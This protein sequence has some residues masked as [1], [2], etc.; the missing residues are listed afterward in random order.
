MEARGLTL[1][2][3]SRRPRPQISA[4]KPISGPLPPTHTDIAPS[5][6]TAASLVPSSQEYASS[7][8][9]TSDLVKRR[10]STRFNQAPEFDSGAAPPVPSVPQVPAA[11]AGLSPPQASTK[12]S[13]E[14]SGPPEVDLTALR[15][16]SLPVDRY[17]ANLL[18]NASEEEIRQYQQ[19]LK[20][21]KNRTSTDLQQNVYQNRTQFIRISQEADKLKGEMRTLRA[22]MAELTTALGQTTIGN[23][24]NPMSPTVDER[25]PKRNANRSSVANLESMW[26]VQLQTLWKTVEGS[27]KF[28]PMVPGRHIVLETG[29]WVE[30]D[31][32]TWKPRRPVHIVLL[33]DHLLVAAKKRKRVDQSKSNHRGPVPTKLVAEECWPLQDV[34]M[35]DLG[36]NLGA[37]PV[38]ENAEDRGISNAINVRVGSK[39]F[40]YRHDKRSSS[41]KIDLLATFRKTVEDLRRTLRSETEAAG[42]NT[43]SLGYMNSRNSTYA[44]TPEPYENKE[45]LRDR[46]EVRIDVDGKQ[47]NLRWVDSQVDELDIDIALQRSEE[48]VSNIERLRKLARGLKGNTVA[49]EVINAKVDE[50]A[51]K[52]AGVLSRSLV[53]THSFPTS[54]KTNVT[55]LTRLGFEDQAREVYLNARSDVISKRIRACIFEGDLPLYIFQISYV[56]FTLIKNTV[57]IYQ[58]CFPSVMTSACI[59]WAKHHL[60]GFNALLTRQ[61][62]SVQRGTTVWQ[63]CID[64]VHEQAGLLAEVGV[65]FSDLVAKGLEMTDEEK[66]DRPQMTRSE[67]LILGLSDGPKE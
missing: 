35:I 64:V 2:S 41:A 59:K 48:A 65:D 22:L 54:T 32:A 55:W 57:S 12:P 66:A 40:T 52:L 13:A 31:S 11:F 36:A 29:N 42:K 5:S 15:D 24:P 10:Y 46:P 33:N 27:Q 7:K 1:R 63:K 26:N 44:P 19:S 34:D 62:S 51:A 39:P 53:D 3:K 8:D 43:E 4:P 60:D 18:A 58:Q 20:K 6:T 50:R 67:S 38:R 25:L 28:L 30:L 9:A 56:Y 61:L 16:P 17:V 49:Q 23:A 21:V 14:S 37:G 45:T 47:Q